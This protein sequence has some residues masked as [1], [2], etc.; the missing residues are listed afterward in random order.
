MIIDVMNGPMACKDR[1]PNEVASDF[2]QE[3]PDPIELS[4]NIPFAQAKEII[5]DTVKGEDCKV[6]L[7][8]DDI[9]TVGVD[10]GDNL[11][12]IYVYYSD[13]VLNGNTISQ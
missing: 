9:I 7:F 11:Q 2:I 6:D 1:H 5:V 3:I 10:K 4:K 13:I 8:I 12:R